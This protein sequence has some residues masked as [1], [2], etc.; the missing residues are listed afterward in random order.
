MD[1]DPVRDGAHETHIPSQTGHGE[2]HDRSD[3]QPVEP[4]EPADRPLDR[5][6]LV[7]LETRQVALELV[8]PHEDVLVDQGHAEHMRLDGTPERV[9]HARVE[10]ARAVR[11]SV[12]AARP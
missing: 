2:V 1:G 12:G 11:R 4:R 5:L 9:D 6:V 8:V 10:P 7:P 3:P